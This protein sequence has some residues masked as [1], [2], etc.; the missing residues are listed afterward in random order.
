MAAV[1]DAFGLLVVGLCWIDD[2]EVS[3]PS[4]DEIVDD[5][6][7]VSFPDKVVEGDNLSVV[8]RKSFKKSFQKIF[9]H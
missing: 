9:P 8:Y 3:V 5:G 2:A 6:N 7:L 4:I 1:V